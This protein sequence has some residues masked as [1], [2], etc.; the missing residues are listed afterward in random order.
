VLNARIGPYIEDFFRWN[1]H[2]FGSQRPSKEILA[3]V[4]FPVSPPPQEPR[5]R[6]PHELMPPPVISHLGKNSTRR[7]LPSRGMALQAAWVP[8]LNPGAF[9]VARWS[10]ACGCN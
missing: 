3:T 9:M 7:I 1:R 10:F 6:H 4:R 2:T 8:H 5:H